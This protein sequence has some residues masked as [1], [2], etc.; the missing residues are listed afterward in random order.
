MNLNLHLKLSNGKI[1]SG[2]GALNIMPDRNPRCRLANDPVIPRQKERKF[3]S[4]EHLMPNSD[5]NS[6]VKNNEVLPFSSQLSQ[7]SQTSQTGTILPSK[8]EE[9]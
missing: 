5:S 9:E 4:V 2:I 7:L 1:I 8:E 6:S 3:S